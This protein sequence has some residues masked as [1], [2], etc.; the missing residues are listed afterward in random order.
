ML[1]RT[2]VFKSLLS[3]LLSIVILCSNFVFVVKPHPM[4]FSIDFWEKVKVRGRNIIQ[5]R[6][7]IGCLP[8]APQPGPEMKPATKVLD[9]WLEL[10]QDQSVLYPLSDPASAVQFFMNCHTFLCDWTILYSCQQC[11]KVPIFPHPCGHVVFHMVTILFFLFYF[12][13]FQ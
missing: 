13:L 3:I 1:L 9:P 11:T 8:H 10:S 5:E 2:R 12:A 4:I 7:L 6:T